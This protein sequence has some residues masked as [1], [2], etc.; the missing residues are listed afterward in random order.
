MKY[1]SPLH[2]SKKWEL[3]QENV[4]TYNKKW[5]INYIF[6]FF[7]I[8]I[9]MQ[10]NCCGVL[11]ERDWKFHMFQNDINPRYPMSCCDKMVK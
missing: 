5:K 10:Y 3:T 7:C 11:N 8:C 6:L 4:R 1:E 9:F 2:I